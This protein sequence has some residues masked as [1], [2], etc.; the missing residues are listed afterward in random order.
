MRFIKNYINDMDDAIADMDNIIIFPLFVLLL[1]LIFISIT[2]IIINYGRKKSIVSHNDFVLTARQKSILID[3]VDLL[4]KKRDECQ[5]AYDEVKVNADKL[6]IDIKSYIQKKGNLTKE[7][8]L[9]NNEL[10]E[11]E[12]KRTDLYN[13]NEILNNAIDKNKT[14]IIEIKE[15]I[16]KLNDYKKNIEKDS[17]S[18]NNPNIEIKYYP[19]PELTVKEAV[20]KYSTKEEPKN[21]IVIE[22]PVDIARSE[23]STAKRIGYAPISLSNNDCYPSVYM[24][25]A[26]SVIKFP[27]KGRFGT[28][29]VSESQFK[30][31]LENF[32]SSNKN[33]RL[34][35]DRFLVISENTAPYEPDFSLIDEATGNLNMF[36]DIEIDEPYDGKTREPLHFIGLDHQRNQF[37][38]KRGWIVIRFSEKQI[39]ENPTGCCKFIA[40]AIKRINNNFQISNELMN[41]S[42]LVTDEFWSKEQSEY[43]AG[44]NY[45]ES[46]L[47][48]TFERVGSTSEGQ[49]VIVGE[50]SIDEIE[51]EKNV[52][53][54]KLEVLF[55][56]KGRE[57]QIVERNK[58]VAGNKNI[59]IELS[60]Y[61]FKPISISDIITRYYL[62]KGKSIT[63]NNTSVL[64][65]QLTTD[66]DNYLN[67]K[68]TSIVNPIL[69][70]QFQSF[71]NK[72]FD[73]LNIYKR[74]WI[75]FDEVAHIAGT[76]NL[77]SSNGDGTYTLYNWIINTEVAR[78]YNFENGLT[79][80]RNNAEFNYILSSLE[81]NIHKMILEKNY[82]K[83]ISKMYMVQF[84]PDIANFN[85]IPIPVL[86]NTT[87]ELFD[88]SKQQSTTKRFYA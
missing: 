46:Y 72:V 20:I 52:I 28:I 34:Y 76:V 19:E 7:I 23:P 29:G 27:R 62:K 31:Y 14:E 47:K 37:F 33:I 78:T 8:K 32:F 41:A 38:T 73:T 1:G 75:I 57:K 53:P 12:A 55:E 65:N 13:V 77:M 49:R 63:F 66:I 3:E 39:V 2:L 54:V 83:P 17:L 56:D 61:S 68:N 67:R 44:I 10:N 5:K 25:Q 36:I 18:Q 58:Q 86:Y 80:W 85:F 70:N 48:T 4:V 30:K 11:L 64:K 15:E 16:L 26:N 51:A 69:F 45:R 84:H 79:N 71:Y 42:T 9:L 24:P 81:M 59:E 87:R 22:L 35:D 40:D 50:Q 43:W 21:P 82:Y 88:F 74:E 60:N 6:L